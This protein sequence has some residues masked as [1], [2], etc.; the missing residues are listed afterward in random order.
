MGSRIYEFGGFRFDG[1]NKTLWR[2]KEMISVPP[3]SL[4]VLSL[5]LKHHGK[6][7]TKQ[8]ILST[9]WANTFVEEGVLTQSIYTLRQSLGKDEDGNQFIEN[10]PRRGYRFATPVK[11]SRTI[12]ENVPVADQTI[13]VVI[14]GESA[15]FPVQSLETKPDSN[16]SGK[17]TKNKFQ[18]PKRK[19]GFYASPA[20]E[21]AHSNSTLRYAIWSVLAVFL[22]S[23]LGF[24]IY[25]FM[26]FSKEKSESETAPIE[27]VRLQRLTDTG[28]VV[29]PTISPD[30]KYL[31]YV[32][33][34]E[35]EE[36]VWIKQIDSDK[37][38]QILPPSRKG[39]R[40]LKFSADGAYLYFREENGGGIFQ[41][42]AFGGTRKKV[43]DN[44]WSE[45]SVSPDGK[46]FAFVRP[47]IARKS[48][49]I[50]LAN[51]DGSGEREIGFKKASDRYNGS[52][53]WSPDGTKLIVAAILQRNPHMTLF[54][55]DVSNG[56]ETEWNLTKWR[57]ISN[58]LW[59]PDG[60]N[61]LI[62]GR[63]FNEQ[64]S[65]IWM[66]S[67]PEGQ[68]RRLTNDLEGYFRLSLS[69]DG[70]KLIARQQKFVLHLWTIKDFDTNTIRQI[71][72]GNRSFDGYSGLAWTPD[73]KIIF[74][75]PTGNSTNLYSINAD[76]SNKIQLTETIGKINSYPTVSPDGRYIVFSSNR[77]GTTQIWKMDIDGQNQTQLTFD[78]DQG[79]QAQ[80]P[81]ISQDG[82][83]VFFIKS[84]IEAFAVWKVPIEGGTPTPVSQISDAQSVG[85]LSIS[86][87]GK[88]LAYH[89]VMEKTDNDEAEERT[90]RIGI[91]SVNLKTERKHFDILLRRPIIHWSSNSTFDYSGGTFN[92]SSFWRQS[93]SSEKPQKLLELPDRVFNFALSKDR[94][95]LVVSRGELQGD[96]ILITN[97]P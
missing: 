92:S 35:N 20:S 73:N 48:H 13:S 86:P 93:L 85:L 57:T 64:S 32:R 77:N 78:E 9:I 18:S 67:Y 2:N 47:D 16:F 11:I 97:L 69:A 12:M 3:K 27:Q 42:P 71:T 74:S 80:T 31:A 56:Q 91:L 63:D 58:I 70:K 44:V 22:L 19:V 7:V 89:Q 55:I 28:D 30:G 34:E 88:Y 62:S 17:K 39:Y 50:I 96:A 40:S 61:L 53:G 36:T 60:E 87:D 25:S 59:L 5:L 14:N 21:I 81:T 45:F 41:T 75:S 66:V 33:H 83:E 68:V 65:Q 37:S 46:L 90:M 51:T 1:E 10:I 82:K 54:I 43:A 76:G 6:L 72:F 23:V 94:K 15:N 8:K 24:G 52:I 84:G 49:I 26:N 79:Q 95:K 29:F 38:I 4:E